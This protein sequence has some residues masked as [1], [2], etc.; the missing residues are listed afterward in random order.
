LFL[1]ARDVCRD[2]YDIPENNNVIFAYEKRYSKTTLV[3]EI[4]YQLCDLSID[5]PGSQFD[6]EFYS[7]ITLFEDC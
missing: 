5:K 4:S 3:G 6:N 7:Q 1:P 2:V